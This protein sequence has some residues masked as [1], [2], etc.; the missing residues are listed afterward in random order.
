MEIIPYL[1]FSG[2]CETAFRFYEQCLRGK[3]EAMLPHAGTPAEAHVPPEWRSKIMHA[4]LVVGDAV[5]M[6]SDAPPDRYQAP[7]GFSV[8]LQMK[9]PAEADRIFHALAENGTVRMPIQQTFWA[10]R[11][12]MLVDRFGIPWMVN[13][14]QA[15]A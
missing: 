14:E 4:R 2:Q 5:L 6:G 13:C 10:V 11:F 3:I 8:T 12:G 7:Q 15:P 1:V 9:D